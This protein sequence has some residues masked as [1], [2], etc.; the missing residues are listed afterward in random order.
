MAQVLHYRQGEAV[1]HLQ[2]P[3]YE[4]GCCEGGQDRHIDAFDGVLL[5]VLEAGELRLTGEGFALHLVPGDCFVV[6][7][8]VALQW[9]PSGMLRYLFIRFPGLGGEASHDRPLKLDLHGTLSPCSPPAAE[10]LLTPTP[11]AWSRAAFEQ[12]A[13]RIGT[14]ACEPYQRR[15]VEPGYSELM[16]I[17]EGELT[18]TEA[19]GTQHT[20]AAGETL[21]VPAGATNAW[22][23]E[24]MVRKVYCILG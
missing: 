5:G 2:C 16:H 3:R 13:L 12:G 9:Q 7:E 21:M 18:L 8:G 14:W 17:L 20:V 19:S 10:V 15:Q 23:S 22:S 11:Q 1:A 6:P 24:T 4:I